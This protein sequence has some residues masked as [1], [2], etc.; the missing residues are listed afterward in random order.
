MTVKKIDRI[1]SFIK[2]YEILCNSL[3]D[4]KKNLALRKKFKFN[5]LN[6]LKN[7]KND[8]NILKPHNKTIT[9]NSTNI[10]SNMTSTLNNKLNYYLDTLQSIKEIEPNL[11]L[12]K[13][14][15]YEY[16]KAISY[17][18][19]DKNTNEALKI[20]FNVINVK[21]HF[22]PAL[23]A[24]WKILSF[25]K[26][27]KL[28]L[29]FS[30]FMIKV[31]H[32]NEVSFSDWIY[33]YILYSRALL[34]NNKAEDAITL[35][36][37]TL[38][39]FVNIPLEEVKFLSEVNKTNKISST[40]VFF[41]FDT[42]LSFY[43]KYHVYQKSEGIFNFNFNLKKKKN[44]ISEFFSFSQNNNLLN[45]KEN[46]KEEDSGKIINN[47]SGTSIEEGGSISV[48]PTL[49]GVSKNK[50]NDEINL[51]SDKNLLSASNIGGAS[52]ILPVLKDIGID[53]VKKI[54]EYLE[55][56]VDL[57]DIP[58]ESPCKNNYY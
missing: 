33:S 35:L 32:M 54:D 20:L 42:A 55:K 44:V 50:F 30:Y 29:N 24:V 51:G 26:E 16:Y 47:G 9:N 41:N 18:Y 5:V 19:I 14:I 56:A 8:K 15:I 37:N 39:V 46:V 25:L 48:I 12:N 27:F 10:S 6:D 2:K 45:S 11:K 7:D 4:F 43:S 34:L 53:N 28:L 57:I 3:A 23:F 1:K 13:G 52:T 36:R 58:T 31:S 49:P 40:N 22:M 21:K 38:D 17:F